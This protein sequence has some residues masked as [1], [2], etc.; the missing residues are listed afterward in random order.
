MKKFGKI[1]IAMLVLACLVGACF[2]LVACDPDKGDD[3]SKPVYDGK[4]IVATNAAF[5]PF[6]MIDENGNYVGIDM[7]LAYEIGKILNYEVEI[8]D[9][10][11]DSVVTSIETG[12]ATIGMAGLT[13]N[14]ERLEHVDFCDPYFEASQVVIAKAGSAIAA[15]T[16]ESS[17]I[18]ALEGKKIGFQ[19][20]T[21]GE[22]YV[23]GDEGWGFPGIANATPTSFQN[24]AA[25]VLALNNGQ[26]DAIVID[27]APAQ[28]FVA[29]NSGLVAIVDIPLTV[30]NYA[31][32]VKKGDTKT[33]NL[34]N[35]AMAILKEKGTFDEI[36]AK[37]YQ[38]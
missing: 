31:F 21:V 13:V 35:Y 1:I 30:E 9:M 27:K 4:L 37:Y 29:S 28:Q 23:R 26:I 11:F 25:A 33:K 16:G 18:A 10:E 14:E 19:I 36:V 3:N 17:L 7:E 22:F 32:A 20:G 12:V 5:P 6:E 2:A 34:V 24:G 8:K 38:E 15:A